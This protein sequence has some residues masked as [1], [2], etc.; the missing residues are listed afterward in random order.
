MGLYCMESLGK[1]SKIN[2]DYKDSDPTYTLFEEVLLNY[3]PFINNVDRLPLNENDNNLFASMD[4]TYKTS[5]GEKYDNLNDVE[6]MS[7][8]LAFYKSTGLIYME[9]GIF[10]VDFEFDNDSLENLKPEL[11]FKG[12]CKRFLS[13][14]DIKNLDPYLKLRV[15]FI[16][17]L[18]NDNNVYT[19]IIERKNADIL[20]NGASQNIPE[21]LKSNQFY[22][23][24]QYAEI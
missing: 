17:K 5:K 22:T 1:A 13:M 20:I 23:K 8:S 7:D 11:S 16:S 4:E 19:L 12:K 21:Y 6:Q 2:Y 14:F 10:T 24:E 3:L 15:N 9:N 18:K